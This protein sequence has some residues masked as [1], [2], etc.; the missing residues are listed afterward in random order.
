M[1]KRLPTFQCFMVFARWLLLALLC[2]P[3]QLQAMPL[4]EL[5][6]NLPADEVRWL[7]TGNKK[8][9]ALYNKDN[10][11]N[12]RGGVILIPGE[13]GN[14][15]S[16]QLLDP[17]RHHLAE[18]RWHALT[19]AMPAVD[20]TE[21]STEKEQLAQQT[22]QAAFSFMNQHGVFNLAIVAEGAS[23]VRASYFVKQLN[24]GAKQSVRALVII[25]ARNRLT[26]NDA[27]LDQM[28]PS[29]ELPLLDIF[30]VS[31]SRVVNDAAERHRSIGSQPASRYRQVKLPLSTGY[32]T[33]EQDRLNKRIRGW[34]QTN[35]S[36]V[37]VRSGQR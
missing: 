13:D 11:G 37:E 16:P 18:N 4:T 19:I 24:Q 27:D 14:P 6:E 7:E 36:G 2:T 33:A 10:S 31:D 32:S 28:I 25:N 5:A 22:L 35:A 21:T 1:T 9:L 29:L 26:G 20:K 34:L 30:G 17:L 12:A 8:V 15:A 3:L 23:A